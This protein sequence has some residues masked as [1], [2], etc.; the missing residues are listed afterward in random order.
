MTHTGKTRAEGRIEEMLV[1]ALDLFAR[2]GVS[3][4]TIVDIA[5][6]LGVNTALLYYYFESKDDLFRACLRYCIERT[7]GGF[8]RLEDRRDDPARLIAAWFQTNARMHVEIRQLVK[9][10]LD[11]ETSAFKTRDTDAVV[12]DFH[13]RESSILSGAIRAGIRLGVF[14]RVN[15]RQ[16]ALFASAHLDGIMLRSMI[17]RDLDVPAAIR[18][19]QAIFLDYLGYREGRAAA[20][21]PVRRVASGRARVP[22]DA[23]AAPH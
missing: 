1:V 5:R 19:L 14:R 11:Y 3:S 18:A 4:V 16:A 20:P 23:R 2:R 21:A 6:A 22:G 7:V 15:V 9:V 8:G 10:M 17:Q 12:R 13:E